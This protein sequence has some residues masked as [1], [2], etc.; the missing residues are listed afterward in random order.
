MKLLYTLLVFFIPLTVLSQKSETIWLGP[1]G[2]IDPVIKVMKK[3]VEFRN[4]RKATVKTYLVGSGPDKL[5][6]TEHVSINTPHESQIRVKGEG[7]SEILTRTFVMHADGKFRFTDIQ[8]GRVRRTGSTS[9]KIPLILQDTV[10]DYYK[11]GNQKSVSVYLNNELISNRNW[12]E[13]G[14][15]YIDDIF[16]SVE[17]EPLFKPGTISLHDHVMNT[18]K[19]SLI[20]FTQVEGRM[21]VGFVV[22]ETGDIDGIRIEQGLIP[23][24]NELAI[25]AFSSLT[26]EWQPARLNG[27][28]VRYY[29]L[30]PINFIY[31][32]YDFDALE[33]RGGSLYWEIN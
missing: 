19:N 7:F 13:N 17:E 6:F 21:I 14:E 26:G 27:E 25:K 3:E 29:Q 20:D 23:E 16:L 33:L 10:R 4:K 1:N 8:D 11:N 28:N 12:K 32:N 24:L 18:F 5:L 9:S 30:F 15:K 31:R 22:M 2:K